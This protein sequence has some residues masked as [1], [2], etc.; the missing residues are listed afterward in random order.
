MEKQIILQALIKHNK[1]SATNCA[2]LLQS[3]Q[4][5]ELL[6]RNECI[7]TIRDIFIHADRCGLNKASADM[8]PII[9]WAYTSRKE[10]AT[11]IIHNIAAIDPKLL[12]DT[13]AIGIINFL[14]EQQLQQLSSNSSE[15]PTAIDS[16]LQ[17]LNYKYNKQLVC[18]GETFQSKL[19]RNYRKCAETKLDTKNCLFQSN[20]ELLMR[21]L[22]LPTDNDHSDT[23]ITNNLKGLYHLICTMER[24]LHYKVFDAENL[25]SCPL[26]KRVGLFLSQIEVCLF[27]WFTSIYLFYIITHIFQI[28]SV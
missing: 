12:A 28:V 6:R 14:D 26:I 8:E 3:I 7:T 1:L 24:L 27:M 19:L 5:N 21:L 15:S 2:T 22:N 10:N 11:Q 17:L 25:M 9:S 18:L 20:Y 13:F 16:H 23:A 4:S